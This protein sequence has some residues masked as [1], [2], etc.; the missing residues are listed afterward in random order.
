MSVQ[1]FGSNPKFFIYPGIVIFTVLHFLIHV[2]VNG[3]VEI[4]FAAY[5]L[6]FY[7]VIY[8]I[9]SFVYLQIG[10]EKNK[11]AFVMIFKDFL[12]MT[13]LSSISSIPV[14]FILEYLPFIT[15]GGAFW[16]VMSFLGIF[17][18]PV[19]II[20]IALLKS[21]TEKPKSDP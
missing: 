13:L 5:S 4:H 17:I 19:N 16:M 14:Y 10:I 6:V 18:Y 7:L 9:A 11:N 8:L 3:G 21:M 15:N 2:L 12:W 20:I 1:E